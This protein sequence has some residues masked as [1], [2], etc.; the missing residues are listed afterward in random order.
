MAV[1]CDREPK[2][3]RE[4]FAD[5]VALPHAARVARL[6]EIAAAQAR[7]EAEQLALVAAFDAD[8]GYEAEGADSAAGWLAWH[9]SMARS[10][11]RGLVRHARVLRDH[12]GLADAVDDLG[13]AKAR[14]VARGAAAGAEA[15]A[16]GLAGL[17]DQVRG[18]SVDQTATAVR[19]WLAY[20]TA[21]GSEP[22]DDTGTFHCP[23]TGG[24]TR[25]SG[26]IGGAAGWEVHRA[27]TNRAE[28]YRRAERDC[29][30]G[31][32]PTPIG[33]LR[34][35]ALHD[36]IRDALTGEGRGTPALPLV[37]VDI[38]LS[39]LLGWDDD[40]VEII[41]YG[42]ITAAEARTLAC[43][44]LVS[45]VITGA[46]SAI[47]ELGRATREP[48]AHQ[49]RA[50]AKRDKG[51]IVPGCGQPPHRC[52]VHHLVEWDHGGFTDLANLC[53]LCRRHHT[54]LHKGFIHIQ[55][56]A[57]GPHTVTRADGTPIPR[58]PPDPATDQRHRHDRARHRDDPTA[59]HPPD[60]GGRPHAP[61]GHPPSKPN[62]GASAPGHSPTG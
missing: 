30:D 37:M 10:T 44:S 50:V 2:A 32:G 58:H 46:A 53:L 51:C 35:R 23:V 48:S 4:V 45:R 20:A 39:T 6:G 38:A 1:G 36:L 13:V 16:E 59:G 56:Q 8:G 7:L 17:V 42:P 18:L 15:F 31:T 33:E 25:F 21:D 61:P 27:V 52:D 19:F 9:C 57:I 14:V 3:T 47:L 60:P 12:P 43:D 24:V 49:R 22:R 5:A 26:G 11:A 41:G 34:A 29:H 40:P 55:P 54:L 28:A 62:A